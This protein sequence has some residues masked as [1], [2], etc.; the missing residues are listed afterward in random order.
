IFQEGKPTHG[1]AF[2]V[3]VR[4]GE[5]ESL[6]HSLPQR[7]LP[8]NGD[9]INVIAPGHVQELVQRI[10]ARSSPLSSFCE[11]YNGIKPF[12]VGKGTPP[13]TRAIVERQPFVSEGRKPGKQWIPLLRGALIG[14][15][16]NFWN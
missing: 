13:Q 16:A 3:D 9:A 7:L 14:R 11:V 8:L 6:L 10:R 12:E 1:A 5:R 2:I 15:Y 4:R